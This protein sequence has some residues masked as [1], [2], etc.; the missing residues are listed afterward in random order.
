VTPL[1]FWPLVTNT[2]VRVAGCCI[3]R[4]HS[5]PRTRNHELL[6]ASPEI[7]GRLVRV[8]CMDVCAM[9]WQQMRRVFLG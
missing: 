1:A 2:R 9:A 3:D 7:L 4:L 5:S 8:I 6:F